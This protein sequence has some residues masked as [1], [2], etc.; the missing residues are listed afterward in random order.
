MVRCYRALQY[1]SLSAG[2]DQLSEVSRF[3]SALTIA[4]AI[5]VLDM[6]A[7]IM[8]VAWM[9]ATLWTILL[10]ALFASTAWRFM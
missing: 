1:I 7:E 2:P 9:A 5:Q 8:V 10:I 6:S 3:L 4:S